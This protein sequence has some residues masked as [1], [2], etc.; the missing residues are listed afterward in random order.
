MT[1]IDAALHAAVSRLAETPT[2]VVASDFDGTLSPIVD[3]PHAAAGFPPCVAALRTLA[4]LADTHVVIISGRELA[5]LHRI[6]GLG[7]PVELIGSHGAERAGAAP[8]PR[9]SH[10]APLDEL[11]ATLAEIIGRTE[12]VLLEPKPTGAAVHVR[13]VADR[14]AAAAVVAAVRAGP[15]RLPGVRTILGKEVVEFTIA[16]ES[17]GSALAERIAS[18]MPDATL[19]VGDDV[20]D[21]D[22]FA[23]L[24]PDDVGIKVG[25][26]RSLAGYR[27][28][29]VP[30]VGEVLA[31]LA[32][33][34]SGAV[35]RRPPAIRQRPCRE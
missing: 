3:D 9:S 8:A 4:S 23:A 21:E 34:R 18:L 11:M 5:V 7:P 1:S 29:D 24:G 22:A 27:V 25:A 17:K 19:F 26:G 33:L 20:T 30:A 12:G 16:T 13:N 6:S 10:A 31:L 2:L 35:E 28:A 15:G 32:D 14:A